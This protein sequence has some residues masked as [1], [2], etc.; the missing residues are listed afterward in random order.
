MLRLVFTR[1]G[2]MQDAASASQDEHPAAFG[3]GV[4]NV[5]PTTGHVGEQL[6]RRQSAELCMGRERRRSENPQTR[7]DNRVTE[8]ATGGWRIDDKSASA[9]AEHS[10]CVGGAAGASVQSFDRSGEL[11][12]HKEVGGS[13]RVGWRWWFLQGATSGR[14]DYSAGLSVALASVFFLDGSS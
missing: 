2:C 5:R 11:R 9:L 8:S 10:R 7:A 12:G 14:P 13:V 4:V 1:W 3:R 6:G